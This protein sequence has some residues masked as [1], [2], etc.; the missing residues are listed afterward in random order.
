MS[1]SPRLD[2]L[3]I[4]A[5]DLA[6]ELFGTPGKR[7]GRARLYSID[8]QRTGSCAVYPDGYHDF[9]TGEHGDTAAMLVRLGAAGDRADA[10]RKLLDRFG[11]AG[12]TLT[13]RHT[14]AVEN[15]TDPPPAAWQRTMSA[16]L[17]TFHSYMK[18]TAP[19]AQRARA[20]LHQR[21]ITD[22]LIARYR[23]GYNPS[24]KRTDYADADR[25]RVSIPPG[26]TIGW[27][28]DGA[29]WSVHVR[30]RE[31][32]LAA[33]LGVRADRDSSGDET[34][35]YKYV[36]G[37]HIRGA[38]FNGDELRDGLPT[39]FVE[40]EF[41]AM[42][43]AA[44]LDGVNVVTL[45]GASTHLAGRWRRRITGAAFVCLDNDQA[46][47]DGAAALL[48][49]LPAGARRLE[50]P[51]EKD[52]TDYVLSGGDLRSWWATSATCTPIHRTATLE[53]QTRTQNTADPYPRA[54][55][56]GV[57]KAL[58][59]YGATGETAL[60]YLLCAARG[61]GIV[62]DEI[63]ADLLDRAQLLCG[64]SLP[65]TTLENYMNTAEII[66]TPSWRKDGGVNFLQAPIDAVKAELCK[67]ARRE[68][69]VKRFR[70]EDS[71]GFNPITGERYT[72]PA[73]PADL[74]TEALEEVGMSTAEAVEAVEG[75]KAQRFDKLTEYRRRT[76]RAAA[77]YRYQEFVKSLNDQRV[78]PL[79]ITTI[80][81]A[82]DLA[83]AHAQAW[84][85]AG[86]L[87]GMSAAE[88]C[89]ALGVSKN[90]RKAILQDVNLESDQ[91]ELS[92]EIGG[93]VQQAVRSAWDKDRALPKEYTALDNDGV[94]VERGVYRKSTV[95]AAIA[96][97]AR[98]VVTFTRRVLRTTDAPTPKEAAG[99][100]NGGKKFGTPLRAQPQRISWEHYPRTWVQQQLRLW[101]RLK[102][103]KEAPQEATARQL[104]EAVTGRRLEASAR[105][106][107]IA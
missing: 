51:T 96:T 14:V 90:T 17:D 60:Y 52:I 107:L 77:N 58:N 72:A 18:G 30:C 100:P 68:I 45:G 74:T 7:A 19:D 27:F 8:G 95:Q 50:L 78:I 69:V 62:A 64:F 85:A 13:A 81:K 59:Q 46:G 42:I 29:L 35:K 89:A 6:A 56:L 54:A 71:E 16:A 44:A 70:S 75:L 22:E 67:R 36:T 82:G 104:V 20:Y 99:T 9:S 40:G 33:A 39:L 66:L 92:A 3:N 15:P 55:A 11:G 84:H 53:A 25:Q 87:E 49:Q 10:V 76:A 38:L 24:W 94:V 73:I 1:N 63:T 37:S 91:Q 106:E 41:D 47:R 28:A 12:G 105:F 26:I 83:R 43:A 31:A 48:Q 65:R 102:F 4:D 61:A 97:G 86:L 21:G 2:Q 34:A 57:V 101:Y 80:R 79:S 93:D 103:G 88:Q 98:V 32:K 5:R 23:L